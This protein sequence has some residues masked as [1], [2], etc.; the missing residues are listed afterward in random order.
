MVQWVT[1]EDE[2][3]SGIHLQTSESERSDGDPEASYRTSSLV[4]RHMKIIMA[5]IAIEGATQGAERL[6]RL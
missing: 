6:W 2:V 4:K 5:C 3:F 1:I